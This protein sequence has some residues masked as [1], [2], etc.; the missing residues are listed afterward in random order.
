[1]ATKRCSFCGKKLSE[2]DK[3]INKNCVDFI[4]DEIKDELAKDETL[5][6]SKDNKSSN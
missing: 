4:F 3:C 6:D 5:K 1:M 2:N